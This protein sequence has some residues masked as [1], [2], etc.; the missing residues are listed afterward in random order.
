[1]KAVKDLSLSE[2][3]KLFRSATAAAK[4]EAAKHDLPKVGFDKDGKL[5]VHPDDDASYHQKKYKG[6]NVA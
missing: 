5:S 1:M 2:L 4:E 6:R 3:D